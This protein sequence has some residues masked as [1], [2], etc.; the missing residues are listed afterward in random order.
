V[1]SDAE[2]LAKSEPLANERALFL[3]GRENR[4]LAALEH[5][6]A[7]PI[8]V[9]G[10]AVTVGQQRITGKE[11]GAAFVH[12]NPLR[13]DRYVVVVAGADVPGTLRAMSL[14]D[15]LPD[16][17][18]WD[19]AIAPSRGQVLLGAGS[20]RAGGVFTK[21]W[22]LPA[23]VADPLAKTSRVPARAEPDQSQPGE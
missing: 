13:P 22:A 11:L 18:V 3:V 23:Q 21:E 1:L 20:L 10:G 6:S 19:E 4:V 2:F 9:E 15:L 12:P 16:F 14:P 7:F 8:H 5:A 17:V